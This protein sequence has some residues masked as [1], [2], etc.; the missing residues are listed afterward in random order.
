MLP[1]ILTIFLLTPGLALG[2][3]CSNSLGDVSTS[4][5]QFDVRQNGT[6]LDHATSLEWM[7]CSMGQ[8]WSEGGCEGDANKFTREAAQ[9]I[10]KNTTFAGH[11]DWR[12]PMLEELET[13]IEE[14]CVAPS[15]NLTVFPNTPS[16]VYWTASS[17]VQNAWLVYFGDGFSYSDNIGKYH[18]V[19]LVRTP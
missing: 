1:K 19:R 14:H 10:A 11:D 3:V 6:A 4:S 16:F 18:G 15:I 9:E 8:V 17:Y 7:R 13:I 12:L 2:Q 5:E